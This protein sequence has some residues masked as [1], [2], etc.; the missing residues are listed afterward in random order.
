MPT[1]VQFAAPHQV[2]LV[3][4]GTQPLR[5]GTVRISTLHSGIS[6]GTELTAYRGT[7]PLLDHT[8]D[9]VGRL[10][11]T[12]PSPFAYPVTGWGY[13]EVG[14]V[15][16]VSSD[17]EKPHVGE[18]V[19]GIWG[20]RSEA[21]LRADQLVSHE[22]PPDLSTL[23]GVFGRVGAVALNAVLAADIR[24]GEHV[25]VFG[26][27][28]IGLLATRLAVLSGAQVTALDTQQP[29]LDAATAMGAHATLN[30]A[31]LGPDGSAHA[32]RQENNRRGIDVAIEL[33][34]TYRALHEAIRGVGQGG[35]V[36][37][38]GFYQGGGSGL[39]LGEEFHHNRVHLVAS[40]IGGVPAGLAPRWNTER[41]H[42]TFMGQVFAKKVDPVPLVTHRFPAAEVSAAFDLLDQGAEALQVVLDFDESE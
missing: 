20:H 11:S 22:V 40:Q 6:A 41:V 8:W 33:S 13:S 39:R 29:R 42:L 10:F 24:L 1:V 26:Q 12:A 38:A 14:R 5:P 18:V 19:W 28:V 2:A 16:E 34:G 25:A 3:R 21:V 7:N 36:I 9:P 15:T 32:L 30:P 17:V 27:G 4:E 31:E 35:T 37:A 23:V